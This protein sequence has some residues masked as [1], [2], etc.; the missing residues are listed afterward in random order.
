[1]VRMLHKRKRPLRDKRMFVERSKIAEKVLDDRTLG[2]LH[3]F[4]SH[5]TITS[6]DYPIAQGKESVVFR[7]TTPDGFAAVKIYKYE[8][9]SFKRRL[10]YLEN[11]PR[12]R[13]PTGV[14]DAVKTWAK[15]EFANL[16]LCLQNGVRVPKPIACRE[17]VV[18]MEY[19][20]E[21]GLPYALLKDVWMEDP[22]ATFKRLL[23]DLKRLRSAGLVHA[24]LSEYNV[25]MK[26]ELPYILDL[27]QA[28]LLKHPAAQELFLKD[29]RN[30]VWFFKRR[31]VKTT[32]KE[33]EAYLEG[34]TG[35]IKLE[36]T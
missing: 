8:T 12:F 27:G 19:L 2:V 24:D 10:I 31:G 16:K 21:K 23:E 22:A 14:R 25:V 29:V 34:E 11:D 4:L 36:N 28:V 33:V 6:L 13:N 20:G 7:A 32:E 30:L 5:K 35:S 26:G 1:M 15:K 18:I 3:Y 9:S 17:N